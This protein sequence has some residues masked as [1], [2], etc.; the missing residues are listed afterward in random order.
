MEDLRYDD[1]LAVLN[2]QR[3][4]DEEIADNIIWNELFIQ[5]LIEE[6]RKE[7]AKAH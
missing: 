6:G 5:A 1:A 7:E 4:D 2:S 3:A